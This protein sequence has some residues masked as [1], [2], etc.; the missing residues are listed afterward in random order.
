MLLKGCKNNLMT[1]WGNDQIKCH[2]NRLIRVS[3]NAIVPHCTKR[4]KKKTHLNSK[5]DCF[6][7]SLFVK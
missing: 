1:K 6:N 5:G 3:T 7:W 2:V 4:K